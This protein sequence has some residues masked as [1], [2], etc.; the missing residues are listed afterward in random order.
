VARA[1]DA[2]GAAGFALGAGFLAKYIPLLLAPAIWRRWDWKLPAGFAAAVLLIYLPYLSVGGKILGFL[3]GYADEEGLSTGDGFLGAVLLKHAGFGAW[4]LPVFL[5]TA[6][7]VLGSLAL[8][9][10]YRSN[11]EQPDLQIA[12]AIATAFMVL[13][14]P[15]LAWYFLWLIPFLCFTPSLAVLYLTLS[16]SAL[17]RLGW[18]PSLEGAA[19][20][21]GPFFMLLIVENLKA[22]SQKE[23]RS[24]SAVA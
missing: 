2:L 19:V 13:F 3:G 18:P 4:A 24:G 1:G 6:A 7:V 14:S 22:F 11:P 17:Y 5:A 16:A 21:Y 23:A 20:M 12:G 10:V 9:A 15:P 8:L